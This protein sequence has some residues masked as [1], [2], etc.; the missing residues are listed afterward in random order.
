MHPLE[1]KF[2]EDMKNIYI[3]AKKNCITT[4]QGLSSLCPASADDKQPS[5][6]SPKVGARMDSKF[7]GK[8]IAS[9]YLLKHWF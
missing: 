2:H 3:V 6:L 9:I 4:L 7:Y 5:N 8:I 1:Y